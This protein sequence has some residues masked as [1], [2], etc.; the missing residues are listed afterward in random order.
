MENIIIERIKKYMDERML[1]EENASREVMQEITLFALS[2]TD[3]FDRVSFCGG[4]CLRIAYGLS[5]ASEDLDFSLDEVNLNFDISKYFDGIKKIFANFGIEVELQE[6]NSSTVKSAFIKN[7][8]ILKEIVINPSGRL[9]T[10]KIKFKI[11]SNPPSGAKYEYKYATFP[12][13]FRYKVFEFGSLFAGKLHAVLSRNWLKGRDYYDYLFYLSKDAPINL[14][15][16]SNASKQT[17]HLKEDEYFNYSLLEE[18]LL[19]KFNEID[20]Q[21]AII[22]CH[23]FVNTSESLDFFKKDF[24]IELTK[25]YFDKYK[26]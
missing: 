25:N 24:F 2:K 1:N 23:R 10:L 12:A 14:E 6:N 7:D 17:G 21:E 3:F 18:R 22:D 8:T 26:N 5:R 11:D 20:F 4:T 16:L 13:P 19:S 15:L 9:K